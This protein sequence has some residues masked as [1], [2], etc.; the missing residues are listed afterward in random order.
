MIVARTEAL[1]FW[2]GSAARP[3][4]DG[5]NLEIAAGEVVLLEGPS[6]GGKSTL[7]RALA[8]L[9]PHFHGGRFAGRVTVLD[10][11]TRTTLPAALATSVG[12]LFQDPETQAVR[13][14]VARDIAFGLEN[15]AVPADRIGAGIDEVLPLVRAEHLRDREI[16]TLSGGERQR[17]ALAAVLALRPRLLLL[18]EPT[19]QI[20]D[21]GVDAL[22]DTLLALAASGVAI[23]I[24][25]HHADRLRR[26]VDRTI[27]LAAGRLVTTPDEGPDAGAP[28][29]AAGPDILWVDGI[30]AR[31]GECA[32]LTACSL[33]LP[34]GT[35]TALH[36]VNGSGKSTLLRVIA[37]LHPAYRGRV[38]V[39]GRDVTP[40]PAEARFPEIGFLPQDAGRRLL[41]ERVDDE[42]ASAARHLPRPAR[43]ERVAAVMAE[44]DLAHLAP[45]HPL[46]LSVGERE[47]V[48]L[49]TVLAG[50]PRVIL[51]DEPSRGMDPARRAMLANAL[52][53]R[54]ASGAAVLV[55]THDRAFAAAIADRHLELVE[56][57]MLDRSVMAGR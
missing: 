3:A 51:L 37:G 38:A 28:G 36:G 23:V 48:A 11:D 13:A 33:A 15:L 30:E 54:V 2:P 29:G 52:R 17:A 32:V 19:S 24:A 47:R 55:A 40:L 31:Y 41:R 49:A 43:E 18:D 27:H 34:A 45:A 7:L 16:A 14:T 12:S 8:G 9:V 46:D 56:G 35:V 44:M 10:Q 53:Q 20:D 5:V 42:V 4:L 22:E 1:S 26:V 21:A 39:A 50:G 57:R 25:E 6:G